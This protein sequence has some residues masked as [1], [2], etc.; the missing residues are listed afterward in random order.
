[1][2]VSIDLILE[3]SYSWKFLRAQ[4]SFILWRIMLIWPLY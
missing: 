4:L 1:M 3:S 2:E